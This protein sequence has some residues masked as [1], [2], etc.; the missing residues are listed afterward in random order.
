M[1]GVTTIRTGEIWLAELD[2]TVGREQGGRRPVVVVSSDG[3]HSLPIDMIM[4][5]PLTGHDRGLVTQPPIANDR[6]G[7]SR[8]SFARPEDLRAIDA[9]RL[10]RRLGQVSPDE[11]AEIRKVLR[12]FLDL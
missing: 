8:V 3:F 12:Y 7:L 11:L 6:A 4:V 5:V 10:Q 1:V 2:P 9:R